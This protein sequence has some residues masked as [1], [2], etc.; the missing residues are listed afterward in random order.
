MN[1]IS[2]Y[3]GFSSIQRDRRRSM[4]SKTDLL[5]RF[6]GVLRRASETGWAIDLAQ[7]GQFA[8]VVGRRN[9][10]SDSEEMKVQEIQIL[11]TVVGPVPVGSN[12]NQVS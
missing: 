2:N 3:N 9:R 10:D 4:N 11:E 5:N 6:G 12:E 8:T 1:E 7:V